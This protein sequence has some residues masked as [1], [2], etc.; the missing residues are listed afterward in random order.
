MTPTLLL[1]IS[2]LL[3][4]IAG[5]QRAYQRWTASLVERLTAPPPPPLRYS[6]LCPEPE[7]QERPFLLERRVNAGWGT[8]MDLAPT[9]VFRP[10][11]RFESY[12]VDVSVCPTIGIT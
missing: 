11:P 10:H 12:G 3:F 9:A 2:G 6:E 7:A 8:I 5:Q 1:V 4:F